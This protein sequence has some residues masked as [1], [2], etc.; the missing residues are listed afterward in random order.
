MYTHRQ[1]QMPRCLRRCVSD[2]GFEISAEHACSV[3][4]SGAWNGPILPNHRAHLEALIMSGACHTFSSNRWQNSSS[5]CADFFIRNTQ[6][7]LLFFTT[8]VFQIVI[9]RIV[10]PYMVLLE[11]TS[12][13]ISHSYLP[14]PLTLKG[15]VFSHFSVFDFRFL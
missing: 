13:S 2:L 12:V 3:K 9:F 4:A 7:F 10:T 15:F 5:S 11:N 6:V 14:L 8:V 1:S